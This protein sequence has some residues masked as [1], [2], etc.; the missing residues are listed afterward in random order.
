MVL[1]LTPSPSSTAAMRKR[2]AL[3]IAFMACFT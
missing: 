2:F 1:I 3:L